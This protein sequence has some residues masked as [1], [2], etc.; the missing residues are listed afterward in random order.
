[1]D[2]WGRRG[3]VAFGTVPPPPMRLDGARTVARVEDVV[4]AG[5]GEQ[6]FDKAVRLHRRPFAVFLQGRHVQ[7]PQVGLGEGFAVPIEEIVAAIDVA[8][9]DVHDGGA[10]ADVA[11]L[12]GLPVSAAVYLWACRSLD[13]AGDK[14]PA[15]A[16]A[17]PTNA[18]RRRPA[19]NG[20]S[21]RSYSLVASRSTRE[22]LNTCAAGEPVA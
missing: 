8:R 13:V 12:V 4:E 11:M 3:A 22:L 10:G 7:P 5:G 19:G 17:A 15:S 18:S 2:V 14:Q 21:A 6:A 20:R 16:A 1:M 9:V